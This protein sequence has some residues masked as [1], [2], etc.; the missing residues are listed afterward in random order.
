MVVAD[1]VCATNVLE[2]ALQQLDDAAALVDLDPD[3]HAKLRIPKRT[4]TVAVP[5]RMDDGSL[6]VFQGIRVQHNMDRGP[7]KG[8]IRYHPCVTMDEVTALAMWM[9]WKCAVVNIP[10]GGAKGGVICDPTVM[11]DKELENLTRRFVSELVEIIGPEQDIP[12]PDV[13]TD[14]RVMGWLMD[15]YSMQKGY[16]VPAVVTGKPIAIGGS[17]GRAKATGRGIVFVTREALKT[18]GIPIEGASVAVQGFGKVGSA[19]AELIEEEG[20]KIIAVS[21]V[22]GG[23]YNPNGL[24]VEKLAEHV[25]QTGFVEGFEGGDVV[26]NEELLTLECDVLVPAALENV[27]TVDNA[28]HVSAKLVVEGANGPTTPEAH[29]IM[30]DRG[31]YVVPDILANA[32]GVTVSYF[33]WCQGIQML[34]WSE[35]EVNRRLENIMVKAYHEVYERSSDL[36]TD[37]RNAAMAVAV[38]RVAEA[39]VARGIYP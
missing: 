4:L 17:L 24:S 22:S 12:A 29:R 3:I 27:L 14:E 16:S 35:D 20:A 34:F 5:T 6:E 31:I 36:D 8:G 39:I 19:F 21:D 33:E 1:M 11:S 25:G 30:V 18:R 26:T 37:M 9:T 15:T 32:G 10:Y 7:C 13:N 23:V 38:E 2:S 28:P